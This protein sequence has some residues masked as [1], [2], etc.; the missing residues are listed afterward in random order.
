MNTMKLTLGITAAVVSLTI[1]GGMAQAPGAKPDIESPLKG[2]V[3]NMTPVG[4][5]VKGEGTSKN[6]HFAIKGA[7]ITRGGWH[8]C[9]FKDVKVGDTVTVTFTAPKEGSSKY[10]ATLIDVAREL[11]AAEKLPILAKAGK[12]LFEDDFAR[13]GMPPKWR[14]GKGFWEIHD[15]VVTAAENPADNHGA[16][17]YAEPRFPYKD[18]VAEFSFKFDGSTGCHL[19]MEDSNYKAAHAGHIIRA[20][21]TPA[22][23]GLADSKFGSMKNEIHDKMKDPATS[24]EEKKRIQESIKDKSASF[25]V[26]LDPAKWHQARVEVVGDEMLI[27]IDNQPLGYLKS[28]GVN[29]P[30]KNMVGFTVGG[31]STQLDNL[32]VWDATVRPDWSKNRSD[33]LAALRKQ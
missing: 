15:G 26:A 21:I 29:H 31:K 22:S 8:P 4:L 28:E 11:S 3:A 24:A 19:M 9:E 1:S 17:A 25:K 27:S 14:L 2:V 18:I 6:I 5:T 32:K 23:L 13:S 7:R 12:L 33:V 30:T 20:T 16:Y 10:V